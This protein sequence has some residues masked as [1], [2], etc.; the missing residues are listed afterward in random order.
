[1]APPNN[2]SQNNQRP[3]CPPPLVRRTP[4]GPC[5][6][7]SSVTPFGGPASG[8]WPSGSAAFQPSPTPA[9]PSPVPTCITPSIFADC[10]G[11]CTGTINGAA[12]GPVCGW[13]YIE[14]FGALGGQ[15]TFTPGVMSMDTFDAD[16]FPIAAKPLSAP[17]ASVF[18]MSGQFDFTEYSTPPN[19]TTTYQLLVN[20]VDLSESFAVS[21]FGDGNI[22]VQAGDPTS[23][24]FYVGTWTPVPGAAH[25]VHFSV[26]GAGVPTLYID[27][28]LHPLL[29]VAN[30]PTFWASYPVNSVSYGGGAGTVA[31][32]VSPLRN[33]F[34]TSGIVGPE[35]VFC[36]P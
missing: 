18:N 28:V 3:P 22:G 24:P 25:V 32:G 12:P 19:A 14:P 5:V 35:T 13:T 17:L 27:G 15:F 29:F 36:C 21:L 11:L 6:P 1:M 26:D 20:N 10:F 31:A 8:L 9:A 7:R 30:V 16:D 33:L 2:R 34:L 23:I 4:T